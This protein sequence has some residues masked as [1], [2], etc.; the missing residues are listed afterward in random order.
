MNEI[1]L[2]PF[3]GGYGA[4]GTVRYSERMVRENGWGQDSFYYVNC[5][6]CGAS[7]VGLVGAVTQ[8]DAIAKWNRRVA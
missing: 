2:C 7:T 1:A 5:M 3:C 4:L 6:S 8:A